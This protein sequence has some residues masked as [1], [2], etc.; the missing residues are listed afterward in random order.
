[1]I[2]LAGIALAFVTPYLMYACAAAVSAMWI[3][4]DP[5]LTGRRARG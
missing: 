5:R 1:M 4:P 3:V 2:Y